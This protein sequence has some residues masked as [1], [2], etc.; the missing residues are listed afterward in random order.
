MHLAECSLDLYHYYIRTSLGDKTS[1]SGGSAEM[2]SSGV[3]FVN[4][5]KQAQ[6]AFRESRL[7]TG[8]DVSLL[9]LLSTS[10]IVEI[11]L[12]PLRGSSYVGVRTFGVGRASIRN[13]MLH[14]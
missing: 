14:L 13:A 11:L 3:R 9:C 12:Y 1:S 8:A 6:L 2:S 4:L 5:V 7:S 10:L